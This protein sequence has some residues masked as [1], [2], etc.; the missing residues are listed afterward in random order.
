MRAPNL[1]NDTMLTH[2]ESISVT[3]LKKILPKQGYYIAAIKRAKTKGGFRHSFASTIEELW[4][5]IENADRD[6]LETYHA[7]ASF[8]EA[9][10][11]PPGTPDGQ[12]RLGRTK[13]NVSAIKTL[14]LDIDAGPGKA[15]N[16][17]K[18]A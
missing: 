13:H 3:F 18:E 1:E 5:I 14:W 12:K 16:N 17:Q 6:G 10:S 7:C 4:A 11:D 2:V 8:K 9:L 15:Y